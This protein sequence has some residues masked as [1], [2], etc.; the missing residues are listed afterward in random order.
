MSELPT[1]NPDKEWQASPEA[2]DELAAQRE[3]NRKELEAA[4]AYRRDE[5]KQEADN[6]YPKGSASSES[7]EGTEDKAA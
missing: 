7:A 6:K 2:F 5:L 3:K 4:A 1:F